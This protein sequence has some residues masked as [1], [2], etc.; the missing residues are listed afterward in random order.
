VTDSLPPALAGSPYSLPLTTTGGTCPASGDATSRIDA[1]ALPAGI[2]VVS[3]PQTRQWSLQ[4][5]PAAAGTFTFSLHLVWTHVQVS[6]F[7]HNCTDEAVKSFTLSVQ[8]NQTLQSDRS[9]IVTTYQTG[10]F[11]PLPV[12]V[13]I[14]ST[15]GPANLSVVAATD[16]GGPWL[17]ASLQ[18]SVTPA[19]V[20]VSYNNTVTNLAPGTYNGRVTVTAATGASLTI[21]ITLQV[22]SPSNVQLQTTPGS[23]SFTAIAGQA[24]PPAQALRISVSGGTASFVF[25]AI[26]SAAPPN[27]K[28]LAV[29]PFA[30]A[31]PATLSVSVTAKDLAVGTYNGSLVVAISGATGGQVSIPIALNVQAAPPPVVKPVLLSGGVVNAAGLNPAIAPGTWVTL[32]GTSLASTTRPW[33]DT[34]FVNGLLPLALDGVSVT[35]NGKAAAVAYVSP[36]QINVLAPDDAATGLVPVQVKNSLGISDSA[37]ALE[38]TAAPAFFQFPAASVNYVAGTHVNGAYLAGPALN[39]QGTSGTPASPGETIVLYGTGFGATLPA[40]SAIA[41]VP[42]PRPLARVE[43]LRI[44]IGGLDAADAYAG[45][46]PP[47]LYQFNVVVPAVADGDQQVTAEL[48]GLLSQANLMLTVQK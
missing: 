26:V 13:Q 36:S 40:I 34:D 7:D 11:P 28:W 45:L 5:T 25:Q 39:R 24:D 18:T 38:Q 31:T 3:P 27:G 17:A 9:Q 35:I 14:T 47:G 42:S 4:G 15:S 19:T 41:L 10:Q 32:Y 29:T 22:V 20:E 48:R 33:R 30:A 12:K 6:P 46:I 1:G 2:S 16:S 23:L 37:L 44:R 43:V 21:P 8:S